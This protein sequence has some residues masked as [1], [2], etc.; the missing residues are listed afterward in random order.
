M[1]ETREYRSRAR[2]GSQFPQRF[3]VLL[4]Q[5]IHEASQG[6]SKSDFMGAVCRAIVE[7]SGCDFLE[8]R[9]IRDGRLFRSEIDASGESAPHVR[10]ESAHERRVG[11]GDPLIERIWSAMLSGRLSAAPPYW[12]RAGSLWIGDTARPILLRNLDD[13]SGESRSVVIGGAMTS[14]AFLSVSAGGAVSTVLQLGSRQRDF[15]SST[16]RR[17]RSLSAWRSPTR[18]CSG[19]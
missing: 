19:P 16:S 12:T 13:I 4:H 7:F 2:V 18:A 10:F 15:F 3:R 17:R 8:L 9:Q 11:E 1:D 5:L 14:V 6:P